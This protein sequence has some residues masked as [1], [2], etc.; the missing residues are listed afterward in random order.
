[1]LIAIPTT[2]SRMRLIDVLSI[3]NSSVE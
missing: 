1:M 2:G 3:R